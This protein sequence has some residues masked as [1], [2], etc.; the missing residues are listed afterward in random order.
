MENS[1]MGPASDRRVDLPEKPLLEVVALEV[2]WLQ[3]KFGELLKQQQSI[4]MTMSK[5][6][7]RITALESEA[8]P[9]RVEDE[10]DYDENLSLL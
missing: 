1:K 5:L 2:K 4:L 10:D 9:A 3:E 7:D 8:L 6:L